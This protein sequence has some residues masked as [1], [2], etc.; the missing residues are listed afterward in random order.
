MQRMSVANVRPKGVPGFARPHDW[1]KAGRV[2]LSLGPRIS[3]TIA[4]LG[5]AGSAA[6][7]R[8]Y[9]HCPVS[10]RF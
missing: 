3:T 4:A 10:W 7:S 6:P 8:H 9:N 5:V 2:E 1:P